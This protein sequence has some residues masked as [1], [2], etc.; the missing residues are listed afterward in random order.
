MDLGLDGRVAVI[1]ASSKGLG[2]ATAQALSAEGARVVLNGRDPDALAEAAASLPGEH[3]V[4]PGDIV[5][6]ATPQTLVDA[7]LSAWG[8]LDVVVGNAGGPP[9]ARA[10]EVEDDAA[11]AAFEA[12]CLASIRLATTAVPHLRERGWGRICFITSAA[13]RQPIPGLA[14]SNIAR[15]GLWAWAKTAAQDLADAGITVNLACPG[16]HPTERLAGQP[17]EGR[18]GDVAG[19]GRVVAFLC[20]EPAAFVNGVALGVD[21]G[22]V[23]GLL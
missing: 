23:A 5:D 16:Q 13:V 8:R 6:P 11:R 17:I 18:T 1:G 15:A 10:L 20:S 21:G 19:F 22:S 2:L 9:R 4:V 14:L 12:N 3:V 7:A